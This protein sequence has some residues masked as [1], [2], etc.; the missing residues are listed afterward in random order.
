MAAAQSI[1]DPDRIQDVLAASEDY[2]E[3][4]NTER[5]SLRQHLESVINDAISDMKTLASSE[6]FVELHAGVRKYASFPAQ[7]KEA[8]TAL[9]KRTDEVLD[10]AKQELRDLSSK[11][12]ITVIIE[13]LD[14]YESYAESVDE[15]RRLV[16]ARREEL[17][18][19][20]K[21][22]MSMTAA[23]HKTTVED[24]NALLE[25][26]KDYPDGGRGITGL[27]KERDQL[28]AK[29]SM[30]TTSTRDELERACSSKSIETIDA[31]LTQPVLQGDGQVATDL[32]ESVATLTAHRAKLADAMCEQIKA[33]GQ[34]EDPLKLED[35]IDEANKY[36]ESV[37][38]H[39]K[40]LTTH[41]DGL[42]SKAKEEMKAL[43]SSDD[44]AAVDAALKLYS[45]WPK[46]VFDDVNKLRNQRDKLIEQAKSKL[47][48]VVSAVDHTEI[49][50]ALEDCQAYGDNVRRERETVEKRLVSVFAMASKEMLGV[51]ERTNATEEEI[52]DMLK[53]YEA[54]PV[55]DK[56]VRRGRDALKAR[57]AMLETATRDK[58]RHLA[59]SSN[60]LQEL[61]AA[62]AKY[63]PREEALGDAY[64]NL[65][66]RRDSLQSAIVEKL[67]G[68]ASLDDPVEIL[69][70]LKE[71]E[72]FE[73]KSIEKEVK[74]VQGQLTKLTKSASDEMKKLASKKDLEYSELVDEI[75]KYKDWPQAKELDGVR[76][77]VKDLE[78][79]AAELIDG[80]KT[81][82]LDL[83]SAP[84]PMAIAEALSEFEPYGKHVEEQVRAAETRRKF[85]IE[86]AQTEMRE[87]SNRRNLKQEDADAALLKYKNYPEAQVGTER[88][89]LMRTVG[90]LNSATAEG[91]EGNALLVEI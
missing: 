76:A 26:Y 81:K 33:V 41:R 48:D 6:A 51:A 22:E 2:G 89:A 77:S 73:P 63:K 50:K 32:K 80:V 74:A 10:K 25:K 37:E 14:K 78:A 91:W 47:L 86:Q 57:L 31:L 54:L 23:A 46:D 19:A 83:C 4:L 61:D 28:K 40:T 43:F 66:I 85:L 35:I 90:K 3:S 24:V 70:L 60:S 79:K 64:K 11:D 15:E 44:F 1:T 82:I 71:A 42:M 68:A 30:V 87:L 69:K 65:Q 72:T 7:V 62:L 39:L 67:S 18:H 5:E 29:L 45:P 20:A 55:S 84:D 36:G 27:K 9:Q 53:K 38:P 13:G 17:V 58:L 49:N 52:E 88:L 16:L 12:D 59:E 8:R 34:E 75:A 21:Q 56:T